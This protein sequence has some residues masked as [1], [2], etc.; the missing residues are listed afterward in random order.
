MKIRH[1]LFMAITATVCS[2]LIGYA[3]EETYNLRYQA[4]PD[5]QL[6]YKILLNAKINAQDIEIN[7]SVTDHVKKVEKDGN[8]SIESQH[9]IQKV[10]FIY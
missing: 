5:D 10:T 3:A 9:K 4:K 7:A 6:E 1:R 2:S 8:V